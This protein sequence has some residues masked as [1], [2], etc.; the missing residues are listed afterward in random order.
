MY[1]LAAKLCLVAALSLAAVPAAAQ[2]V[3][4]G[5]ESTAQS[6]QY[7]R[8]LQQLAHDVK[9]RAEQLRLTEWEIGVRFDALPLDTRARSYIHPRHHQALIVLD[10]SKPGVRRNLCSIIVHELLHVWLTPMT[11]LAQLLAR[12]NSALE[13]AI[14]D[15][16]EQLVNELAK[17]D[18]WGCES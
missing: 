16:E 4:I 13:E 6:K 11:R 5:G 1:A 2:T 8:E 9:K 14:K 18:V 7:L 17:V 3:M 12:G 15:S 10:W